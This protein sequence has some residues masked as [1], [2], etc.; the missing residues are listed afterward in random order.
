M[1]TYQTETID[2]LVV[3]NKDTESVLTINVLSYSVIHTYIFLDE[4]ALC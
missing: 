1:A 3:Q 2:N 4:I